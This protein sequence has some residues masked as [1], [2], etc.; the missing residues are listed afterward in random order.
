[1]DG[2]SPS[3]MMANRRSCLVH[4]PQER[5]VF[6]RERS[7][8]SWALSIMPPPVCPISFRLRSFRLRADEPRDTLLNQT[9]AGD[10]VLHSPSIL[11]RGGRE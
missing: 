5:D 7:R 11:D 2:A 6:D 1:V 9:Q 4:V 8:I 3:L 10:Q